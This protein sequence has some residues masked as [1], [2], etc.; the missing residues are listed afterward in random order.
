MSTKQNS[1]K[2]ALISAA[3]AVVAAL[4]GYFAPFH[5]PELIAFTGKVK[6]AGSFKAIGNAQVEIE[7]DQ[8]LPQRFVTDSEGVFFAQL[9]PGAQIMFLE[10]KAAGYKD[11]SRRGLAVRSG[12]EVILL[13]RVATPENSEPQQG[14]PKEVPQ[15]SH[16]I[17]S[18]S[19][20][21]R[22]SPMLWRWS[23]K[24][25]LFVDLD[26][27]RIGEIDVGPHQHGFDFTCS[28]GDHNYSVHSEAMAVK[29]AGAIVIDPRTT[30]LELVFSQTSP[31][32]PDCSVVV[33]NSEYK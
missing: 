17:Q 26:G 7:E 25:K 16:K 21:C 12:S 11:Y 18:G 24:G 22:F 15:I 19:Q 27:Q 20:T 13:E 3:G 2:V 30:A 6:E 32:R 1:I 10:I 31:G 5:K 4:I 9:S 23:T 33:A 14:R 28:A 29:C 8:K